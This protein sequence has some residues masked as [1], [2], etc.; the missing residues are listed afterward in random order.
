MKHPYPDALVKLGCKI[1]NLRSQVSG[2]ADSVHSEC[3]EVP[4]S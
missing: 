4:K 1:E 2:E 3:R